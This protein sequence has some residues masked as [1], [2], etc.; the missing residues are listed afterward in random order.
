MS[1]FK[2]KEK[3]WLFAGEA[4]W[5]FVTLPTKIAPEIKLRTEWSKKGWGSVRVEAKIGDIIWKTSIFPE[6]K[7][8]SYVLPIKAEVRKKAKIEAGDTVTIQLTLIE[9]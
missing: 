6:K 7:T 2:I 9:S 1:D 8:G 5:H 3:V 4:A